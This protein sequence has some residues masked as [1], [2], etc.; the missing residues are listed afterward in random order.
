MDPIRALVARL[1]D[2]SVREYLDRMPEESAYKA[3]TK[4]IGAQGLT[5]ASIK[6]M[7]DSATGDRF[8][9]I[10]FVDG[11]RAVISSR[12]PTQTR[13]PGW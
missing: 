3:M 9:E 4:I 10:F 7:I 5:D 12:E 8:V 13:G 2:K 11:S 6:R 1:V